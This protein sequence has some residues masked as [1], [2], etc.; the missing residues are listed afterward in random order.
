MSYHAHIL[1]STS[2][3]HIIARKD[4]ITGDSVQENDKVVFCAACKSCFLEESWMYMNEQHCEQTKT[5]ATVPSMPTR[6]VANK[7]TSKL[8][9]QLLSTEINFEFML[10]CTIFP[11]LFSLFIISFLNGETYEMEIPFGYTLL[12]GFLCAIVAGMIS[13]I[14]QSRYITG[15][16][17]T[18][19]RIFKTH[20]ELGRERY[21]LSDIKQIKYQ[22]ET[23]VEIV[24]MREYYSSMNPCLLIYFNSGKF[25]THQLPTNDYKT[26]A[27]FIQDLEKI[28]YFKE[29]F[30]YSENKYEY[31]I[32]QNIQE[33]SNGHIVV[34]EPVRLLYNT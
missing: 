17:I 27:K 30:L 1:N 5:L 6:L 2:H 15:N 34:G 21:S 13:F 32:I 29:L 3:A 11:F 25:I 28:S 4:P 33:N 16:H 14:P 7:K 20:I 22:R 24:D 31:D 18:D 26:I 9:A 12:V 8:I 23:Q 10:I 19:V